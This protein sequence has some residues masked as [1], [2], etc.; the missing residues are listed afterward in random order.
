MENLII[1]ALIGLG[2]LIFKGDKDHEQRKPE[3]GGNSINGRSPGAEHNGS[4]AHNRTRV[5]R[6]TAAE[7]TARLKLKTARLHYL[8]ER[9]KRQKSK[10]VRKDEPVDKEQSNPTGSVSIDHTGAESDRPN[11][12]ASQVL[13]NPKPENDQE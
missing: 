3:T 11:G 1:G 12:E 10:E 8:T 6:L 2:I 13:D 9:L 5:H 4:K 7:R